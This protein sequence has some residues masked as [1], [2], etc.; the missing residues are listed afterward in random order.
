MKYI[1]D[2]NNIRF[3]SSKKDYKNMNLF[4]EDSDLI[5]NI[6][7]TLHKTNKNIPSIIFRGVYI[8][9]DIVNSTLDTID[10]FIF[11]LISLGLTEVIVNVFSSEDIGFISDSHVFSASED[12]TSEYIITPSGDKELVSYIPVYEQLLSDNEGTRFKLRLRFF[13]L[14]DLTK[15]DTLSI[16]DLKNLENQ[17]FIARDLNWETLRK[18]FLLQNLSLSGG[19][20]SLRQW[21]SNQDYQLSMFLNGLLSS[22]LDRNSF[23]KQNR[24]LQ[25]SFY[26]QFDRGELGHIFKSDLKLNEF[27][28]KKNPIATK[29]DL[30]EKM[31]NILDYKQ[32]SGDFLFMN[33]TFFLL[34]ELLL[35]YMKLNEGSKE[36][37]LF[38][39]EKFFL[40]LKELI[41][42]NDKFSILNNIFL[43]DIKNFLDIKEEEK[44]ASSSVLEELLLMINDGINNKD[45]YLNNPILKRLVL[46]NDISDPSSYIK[47]II[48]NDIFINDIKD[49]LFR[50]KCELLLSRKFDNSYFDLNDFVNFVISKGLKK[51]RYISKFFHAILSNESFFSNK[52]INSK[53][54]SYLFNLIK[55]L[56]QNVIKRFSNVLNGMIILQDNFQIFHYIYKHLK[57]LEVYEDGSTNISGIISLMVNTR[58]KDDFGF[59]LTKEDK[60]ILNRFLLGDHIE[61]YLEREIYAK[62]IQFFLLKLFEL[63]EVNHKFFDE[64]ED[65][66][67]NYNLGRLDI[68]NINN[69][70]FFNQKRGYSTKVS[71]RKPKIMS[72]LEK[73][74]TI[75]DNSSEEERYNLQYNIEKN[76]A[77]F[78]KDSFIHYD[79]SKHEILFKGLSKL[80]NSLSIFVETNRY[81]KLSNTLPNLM[82]L[83]NRMEYI[84]LAISIVVRYHRFLSYT[85]ICYKLGSAVLFDIYYKNYMSSSNKFKDFK[86]NYNFTQ[87]NIIRLGH[88][89]IFVLILNGIIKEV[90]EKDFSE[91]TRIVIEQDYINE[92]VSNMIVEPSS[93]PMISRPLSWSEDEF[94]GFLSN[95]ELKKDVITGSIE[96]HE[97][98][99]EYRESLY[100]AINTL[101]NIKFRI[102]IE[103]LEFLMNE[104]QYLIDFKN[105]DQLISLAAAKLFKDTFFFL[106]THADW[107]G[108][109]YTH[110]FYLSYQGSDIASSLLL[111]NEGE[112]LNAEGVYYLYIYGANAYNFNNISKAP[113]SK[114]IE[115]V[116]SNI[117]KI[118]NMEKDFLVKAENRFVFSAFCLLIRQLEKN[119]NYP[120]YLPVFL[121]ATCSGIQHISA[122]IK[123]YELGSRVN[124]FKVINKEDQ[125]GDIYSDILGPINDEINRFGLG[126]DNTDSYYNF[127]FIKLN[128]SIVKQSIMTKVY[129]V[130][131]Y[132]IAKQLEN[133][134]AKVE[135]TLNDLKKNS[136]YINDLFLEKEYLDK[137]GDL[138]SN[139]KIK[140][141]R[142]K[143]PAMN[144]E[145]FVYVSKSQLFKIASIINERVFF[146]FPSLKSIYSYFISI[147]KLMI[148]LGIPLNWFTPNGIKITQHYLKTET[149]KVS[150]KLG[151]KPKVLVIKQMTNII[152]KTKQAQAIIPN[153]I[154]SL[155]ASHLI[156]VINRIPDTK[157]IGVH[158]C[159]GTSP[160]KMGY[161][162]D[163]VKKEFILLYSKTNFLENFHE[164]VLQSLKDHHYNILNEN[165]IKLKLDNKILA[166]Q[167]VEVI[168][169]NKQSKYL[170]IP[171]LPKI[172]DLDMNQILFSKYFLS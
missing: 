110:S 139:R 157:V 38:N 108:R 170:P 76:W 51:R 94:G 65:E 92:I 49:E 86:F 23:L 44:D 154:H 74:E 31:S 80:K 28:L 53:F 140:I 116:M 59:S 133:K 131:N 89:F 9:K 30:L 130:T 111:F 164:R 83:I 69:L 143:V 79:T 169:K 12:K 67:S 66:D 152:D 153:I 43:F 50:H 11:R 16:L 162:S 19:N 8:K 107:R 26:R 93:L 120:V 101:N 150:I 149:K 147:S 145:G 22:S 32:K 109:I 97:H 135:M 124:L 137:I 105:S 29:S 46:V 87:E 138:K 52:T 121:D 37:T 102:N 2:K 118:L 115:W 70:P 64:D 62:E 42:C 54:N 7:S 144:R 155:D 98:L 112:V 45:K 34:N 146:T 142:F 57:E 95:L 25:S 100:K 84:I 71:M 166:Y 114:R 6:R 20:P 165:Q 128:R 126:R 136:N 36:E 3:L 81:P 27:F 122:L 132:G 171:M 14:S 91:I 75:S 106:N 68:K 17:F 55:K 119:P 63:N 5:F 156:N 168:S 40:F 15:K 47:N 129:N 21:C 88:I 61:N 33:K 1:D 161:L 127:K 24:L 125:I 167:Y 99:I 41:Q 18:I 82:C 151:N 160:N 159:F 77:T 90:Y 123:D 85:N 103:L 78:I 73:L 113:F 72:Y 104:G 60:L 141:T 117:D 56:N 39:I 148:S 58:V 35:L 48:L 13:N 158:D 172:G 134:L 10:Y 4:L 163:I 96:R